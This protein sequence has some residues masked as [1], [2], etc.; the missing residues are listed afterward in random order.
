MESQKDK[1]QECLHIITAVLLSNLLYLFLGAKC[2]Y[3]SLTA[4][5]ANIFKGECIMSASIRYLKRRK[6]MR[7]NIDILKRGGGKEYIT[8]PKL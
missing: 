4:Q 5:K 6:V 3:D 2:C 7:E 1:R 8:F